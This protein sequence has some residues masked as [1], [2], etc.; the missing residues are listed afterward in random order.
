MKNK[1]L[2]IRTI[3]LLSSFIVIALSLIILGYL[4]IKISKTYFTKEIANQLAA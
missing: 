4:T 1:N 3:V 2:K